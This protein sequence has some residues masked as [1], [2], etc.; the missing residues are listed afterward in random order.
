MARDEKPVKVP[1]ESAFYETLAEPK[2]VND[3]RIEIVFGFKPTEDFAFEVDSKT[4]T[5]FLRVA[6]ADIGDMPPMFSE[7]GMQWLRETYGDGAANDMMDN[8]YNKIVQDI[9][10]MVLSKVMWK[11]AV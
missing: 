7:N 8:A 3:S 10:K 9:N 5:L 6:G 11:A 4:G 2:F 1:P